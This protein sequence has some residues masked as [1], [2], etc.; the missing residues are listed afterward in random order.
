MNT[1]FDIER[2]ISDALSRGVCFYRTSDQYGRSC[3]GGDR[4][5]RPDP[6]CT[7]TRPGKWTATIDDPKICNRGYHATTDPVRWSGCRVSVVEVDRVAGREND[8]IVCGAFREL[9]IVDPEKCVD[10][11]IYVAA[12]RP[13]LS[14]ANLSLANLSQANLSHAD[15]SHADLSQANLSQANL[16]HA[17]LYHANLSHAN[18]SH[19]N[20][21]H[22]NLSHADLYHANLSQANLSQANLYHANLSQANLS[23][24]NLSH[25]DLS[26]ANLYQA[27]LSQANL[28]HANLSQAIMPEGWEKS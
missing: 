5:F 26:Q 1:K 28:S 16:Y 13:Y 19:A 7:A 20:L 3:N 14:L 21:S 18:L 6:P 17:N 24:A 12:N 10:P 27:N 23:Q 25:A 9:A 11:R 15:L 8:K 2:L 22:A 4:S